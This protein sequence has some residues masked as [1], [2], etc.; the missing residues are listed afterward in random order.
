VNNIAKQDKI[1]SE[2]EANIL[3]V[4]QEIE[5]ISQLVTTQRKRYHSTTMNKKQGRMS[6]TRRN[7]ADST[8]GLEQESVIQAYENPND[9]NREGS[10]GE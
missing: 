2:N 9:K 1:I 5:A 6:S 3:N 4:R 7:I 8:G 10:R